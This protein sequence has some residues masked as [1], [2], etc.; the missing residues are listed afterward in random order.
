MYKLK[1]KHYFDAAHQLKL[2]YSSPCQRMHG[3]RWDVEIE[4]QARKLN[5]DGMIIDFKLLKEVINHLDHSIVN[6]KVKFNPTAENISKYFHDEIE[7]LFPGNF[8]SDDSQ[9]VIIDVTVWESPNASITY[10]I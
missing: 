10:Y 6:D 5:K 3:H 1:L 2:S 9:D 4:I 8:M 7:K